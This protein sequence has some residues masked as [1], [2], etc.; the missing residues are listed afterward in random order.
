MYQVLI[1]TH[2]VCHFL[3]DELGA[4]ET[5]KVDRAEG[6]RAETH[7][8]QDL[9]HGS[10]VSPGH[11]L[12][13]QARSA[14]FTDLTLRVPFLGRVPPQRCIVCATKQLGQ[15]DTALCFALY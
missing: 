1:A 14:D 5:F 15:F 3:S 6:G 8:R 2:V 13:T 4:K 10:G 11:D 12:K 9:L 7:P